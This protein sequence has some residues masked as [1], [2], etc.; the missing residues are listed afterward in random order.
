MVALDFYF[1]TSV[2][3]ELGVAPN[4]I[5][6][7]ILFSFNFILDWYLYWLMFHVL[8]RDNGCRKLIQFSAIADKNASSDP[9]PDFISFDKLCN[10][11]L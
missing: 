3:V 10:K 8:D 5:Q 9:I 7:P 6:F 11:L 1:L 4:T 2:A